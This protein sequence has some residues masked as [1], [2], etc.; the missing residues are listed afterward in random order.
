MKK[1]AALCFSGQMR[2]VELGFEC[3]KENL[4]EPNSDDWEF[5]TFVHTWYDH[6]D[7]GKSYVTAKGTLTSNPALINAATAGD[8]IAK[9]YEYYNPERFLLEKQR[10]FDEKDYAERKASFIVPAYSLSKNYS[11]KT[12][13]QLFHEY[14]QEQPFEFDVAVS[15]RFDAGIQSKIDLNDM[16][17]DQICIP[18]LGGWTHVACDVT[19]AFMNSALFK[20]YTS[21][22][23]HMDECFREHKI[24]FSDERLMY[25]YLNVNNVPYAPMSELSNY[26]LIRK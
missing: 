8:E 23:D 3:L 19:Y 25:K 15:M 17:F 9:V 1:R 7:V 6:E 26:K 11:M 10:I 2:N 18:I 16:D 5:T 24:E 21:F 12:V 14:E 4:L 20:T 22:Y 13:G